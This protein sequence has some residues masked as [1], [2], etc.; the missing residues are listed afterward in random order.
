MSSSHHKG[1][2]LICEC[3]MT[4]YL[5]T[6]PFPRS[7][8]LG[9]GILTNN[10]AGNRSV[11]SN[12][13]IECVILK[14]V[15]LF[16]MNTFIQGI[17]HLWYVCIFTRADVKEVTR[18][19]QKYLSWVSLSLWPAWAWGWGG[20]WKQCPGLFTLPTPLPAVSL[21]LPT[22]TLSLW[23]HP[24]GTAMLSQAQLSVHMT[25][26]ARTP[27]WVAMPSSRGSCW[28]R[29]RT[30]VSHSSCIAGRFLT[31]EQMGKP[32]SALYTTPWTSYLGVS[33]LTLLPPYFFSHRKVM[34]NLDSVLK[35]RDITLPTK[36]HLVKAMVFPVVMYGCESWTE[37]KAES[38]RIEA[39][40]QWC[41]RRLLRVPWTARRSNQSILKG[42]SPGCSLEGLILKLKLQY[43]GYLMWKP[44]SFEKTLMLGK[45]ESRRRRGPQRMRWWDGITD[46]MDMG[47]GGLRELVMTGR[48][49]VLWFMGSERVGHAWGTELNWS[50]F[51]LSFPASHAVESLNPAASII[52]PPDSNPL[53]KAQSY[54]HFPLTAPLMH[55]GAWL[56]GSLR[57][58]LFV[59]NYPCLPSPTIC[60]TKIKFVL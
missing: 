19:F 14:W 51:P 45:T 57:C 26:W 53:S 39:F 49:G 44:E 27:K 43:F 38:Q 54:K 17:S 2:N 23:L 50:F 22:E 8:T 10:F 16:W 34:T 31:A 9:V 32:S 11:Q 48:P 36:V 28:P 35:I 60:K 25:L 20:L 3:L 52:G 29:D 15:S 47:L 24:L 42:I 37:K 4:Y 6:A 59:L 18:G 56:T 7:V 5:P 46:S 13:K 33:W 55:S 41:W 21:P 12:S 58:L 1:R 30:H 40:E